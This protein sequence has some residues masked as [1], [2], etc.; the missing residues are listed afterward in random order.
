M[1]PAER[2]G[3]RRVRARMDELLVQFADLQRAFR[4][5]RAQWE[6]DDAKAEERASEPSE[7][8]C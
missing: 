3:W 1:T 8:G 6:R 2:D 7:A 4:E 5:M